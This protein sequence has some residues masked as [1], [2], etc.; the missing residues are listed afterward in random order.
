MSRNLWLIVAVVAVVL[1]VSGTMVW[2]GAD[3]VCGRL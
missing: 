1:A 3:C 2:A